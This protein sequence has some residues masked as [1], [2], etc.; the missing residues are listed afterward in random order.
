MNPLTRQRGV[1]LG[2]LSSGRWPDQ[3]LQ[4]YISHTGHMVNAEGNDGW[5]MGDG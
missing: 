3:A 5:M 2:G 4:F 1:G